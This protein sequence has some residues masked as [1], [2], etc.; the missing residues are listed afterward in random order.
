M[1]YVLNN[2][3]LLVT[4]LWICSFKSEAEDT[5]A[6]EPQEVYQPDWDKT[7]RDIER[8]AEVHQSNDW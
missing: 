6:D 4:L 1:K 3:I 2:L 7:I 8:D 5:R